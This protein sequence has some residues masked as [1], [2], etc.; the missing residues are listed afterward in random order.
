MA[1]RLAELA[2]LVRAMDVDKA[3]ARIDE[4]TIGRDALIA[5]RFQS[6]QPE[7]ACGDKIVLG[8]SPFGGEPPGRLTG[9]E[10]RARDGA[11]PDLLAN[12]VESVRGLVRIFDT[13]TASPGGADNVGFAFQTMDMP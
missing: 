13:A 1:I 4:L 10:D 7:D 12:L 11:C 5:T 6:V 3:A 9:L 2:G 8:R